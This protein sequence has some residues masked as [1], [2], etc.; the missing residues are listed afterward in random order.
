MYHVVGFGISPKKIVFA[1]TRHGPEHL[2]HDAQSCEGCIRELV[3]GSEG[4]GEH[5]CGL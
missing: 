2:L 1:K 3:G 4:A 5:V